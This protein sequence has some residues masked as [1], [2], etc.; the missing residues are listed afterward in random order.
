VTR[1]LRVELLAAVF[2]RAVADCL[3]AGFFES[4][5]PLRGGA[6][7]ADW[8]LCG[9]LSRLVRDG[10]LRGR[11]GEAALLLTGP[12][13]ASPRLL[14]V[15]CGQTG[16]FDRVALR[17]AMAG[18][19]ARVSALGVASVAL[20]LPFGGFTGELSLDAGALA[21][22]EG[23][24]DTRAALPPLH[25]LV[26]PGTEPGIAEVMSRFARG[27]RGVE[28]EVCVRRPGPAAPGSA[29]PPEPDPEPPAAR[30]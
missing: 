22:V 9:Q 23:A 24:L 14:L 26:P 28:I 29:R 12:A 6:G 10:R 2:E 5:R 25:L 17:R 7:R 15:G 19:L 16:G 27:H 20:D 1:T 3:L 11:E 30:P 21:V 4:E 8:R 13:F 18:A